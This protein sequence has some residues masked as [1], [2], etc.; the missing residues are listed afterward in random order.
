[1][2]SHIGRRKFLATLG[3]AAAAW[4]LAARAQQAAMPVIGFL[5][6]G[7]PEKDRVDGFRRALADVGEHQVRSLSQ[8][9]ERSLQLRRSIPTFLFGYLV[10]T[11]FSLIFD[12]IPSADA[13]PVE[14]PSQ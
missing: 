11:F 8:C 7:S 13:V 12:R 4:P 14:V 1:M 5:D 10:Q 2:A 6:P 9:A 3:G